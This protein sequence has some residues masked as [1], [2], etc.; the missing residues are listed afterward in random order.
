M[1]VPFVDL[2]AQY[3]RYKTEIDQAIAG[4]IEETAFV[5]GRHVQEF[6]QA[7]ARE[8]GAKHCV[9]VANGTDALFLV[10]KLLGLGP[11][12]EVIT[13]AISWIATP[14]MVS[15]TG[16]KP[17]FVDI[18]PET[19]NLDPKLLEQALTENTKAILPVHL[20]G[21]MTDMDAVLAF[22]E[23][24]DLHVIEDC[25]QSHFSRDKGRLAGSMGVAGTFSFYPGKNLGAY[26]DAGAIVIDDDELAARIRM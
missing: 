15:L 4:V 7:F 23:Q 12:D 17:V 8:M 2:K 22:A 6:E 13:T 25:A 24:H 18:D 1:H 19:V 20:Y 9:G 3:L 26:G 10:M 16:A 5:G 14:E 21:Q 11:G